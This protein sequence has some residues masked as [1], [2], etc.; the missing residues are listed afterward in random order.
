MAKLDF[1]LFKEFGNRL[2]FGMSLPTLDNDLAKIYEPK[3]PSPSK[4]LETLQLA[5]EKGLHVFV[6][7]APTYPES[8]EADLQ[9][10]MSAIKK[11]NPITVYHEPINIRSENVERIKAHAKKLGKTMRSEVFDT[12][13]TWRRYALASMQAVESL[14]HE[15]EMADRLHLWPDQSLL[16]ASGFLEM[17]RLSLDSNRKYTRYEIQ[18]YETKWQAE[19]EAVR[20]WID[21][22]HSRISEWPGNVGASRVVASPTS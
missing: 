3:A 15:L 22:W 12:D 2:A 9:R 19:F 13:A 6:A 16:S 21:Q 1:D 18:N 8:D 7:M 20:S 14:A 17:K 10:T 4:R 5:V 11:L